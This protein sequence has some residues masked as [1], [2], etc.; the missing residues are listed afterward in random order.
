MIIEQESMEAFGKVLVNC[1]QESMQRPGFMRRLHQQMTM[2]TVPEFSSTELLLI[3]RLRRRKISTDG[4]RK[5]I[6]WHRQ[7]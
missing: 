6:N 4:Q 3:H 1:V 5:F 2:H 7:T